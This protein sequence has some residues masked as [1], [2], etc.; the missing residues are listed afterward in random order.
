[1]SSVLELLLCLPMFGSVVA[2][3]S[4][5]TSRV[6]HWCYGLLLVGDCVLSAWESEAD[7]AVE[8]S[9]SKHWKSE[10]KSW[11]NEK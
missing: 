3:L 10:F 11:L 5:S 6:Q 4:G 2:F 8:W 9:E 7:L 1:M